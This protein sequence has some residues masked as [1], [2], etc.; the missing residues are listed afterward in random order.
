MKRPTYTV[1]CETCQKN[2]YT[3]VLGRGVE[4]W[5]LVKATMRAAE[6]EREQSGH[7]VTVKEKA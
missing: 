3:Y 7:V 1:Y 6:H 2:F 5:S 4:K